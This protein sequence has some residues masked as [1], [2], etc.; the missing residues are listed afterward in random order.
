M[1][2]RRSSA[3]KKME[4]TDERRHSLRRGIRIYEVEGAPRGETGEGLSGGLY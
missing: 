1:T 4:T 3:D 2:R